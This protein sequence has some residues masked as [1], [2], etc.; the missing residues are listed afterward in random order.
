MVCSAL[1]KH[2]DTQSGVADG[3]DE[4]TDEGVAFVGA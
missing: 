3:T 1:L 4:G 2:T